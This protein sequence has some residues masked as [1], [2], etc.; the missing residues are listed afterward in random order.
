M[1]IPRIQLKGLEIDLAGAAAVVAIGVVAYALLLHEPLCDALAGNRLQEQQLEAARA[2]SELQADYSTRFR[3]LEQ[4]RK[5]L[6]VRAR[7][8]MS[9]DPPTEVL[10]RINEFAHQCEVRISRWQPQETESFGEYQQQVFAIDGAATWPALLQWLALVEEGVPLLD[11]THLSIAAP[12][13]PG[14]GTCE[15]ACSLKLYRGQETEALRVAAVSAVAVD[16][17]TRQNH[18]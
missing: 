13:A 7:W 12:T 16:A 6:A 2:I 8:L 14:Q 10:A 11:V 4:T 15:F 9:P 5:D 18:E 17:I 3:K 1:V